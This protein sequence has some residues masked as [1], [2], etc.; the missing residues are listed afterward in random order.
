MP[1]WLHLI[2]TILCSVVGFFGGAILGAFVAMWGILGLHAVGAEGVAVSLLVGIPLFFGGALLGLRVGEGFAVHCLPTRCPQC[3]GR[4]YYRQGRPVTYH[5]RPCGHVQETRV[6]G[7]RGGW[8]MP[9][10]RK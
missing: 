10:G 6:Y 2:L 8:F 1:I 7:G 4:T 5:C 3:G 9:T